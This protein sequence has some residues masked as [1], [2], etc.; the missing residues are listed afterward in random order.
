[1]LLDGHNIKSMQLKWLRDQM[2][3]VNQE[4]CLFSTTIAE[5]IRYG[6]LEGD[7]VSMDEVIEVA[8]ISS[9]HDFINMLPKGYETQV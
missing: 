9:A 6:K 3:L 2:G 4:P 8:K 7:Q 5:N 1:M